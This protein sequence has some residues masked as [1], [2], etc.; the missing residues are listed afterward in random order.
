MR[1]SLPSLTV[2]LALGSMLVGSPLAMAQSAADA[3]GIVVYNA[4]HESLTAGM[5]RRLHQGDRHQGDAAQG[6]RHAS[7]ATRSSQEGAASPGRRVPDRE[8]A[9]HGAG[10]R[11]RPVRAASTPTRW[12]RCPTTSGRR[13]ATGSASPRASTVF[14]YDKTKLTADQLPKSLLDLAD[15][16]WKGRWAASPSGADFQAI[17]S[18]LLRAQ[19]RGG[20]RGLA[21][22]DEGERHRLQRQQRRHEGRQCRRDRRRRDLSLL[23]FR[24]SGEDRREQQQRRRCTISATRIRA[25]SSAISGGGVLAS[26]KHPKRGAGL[27]EMDHRQGRPGHPEDRQFVRIRGRRGRRSPTRSWCRWPTCRRPKVDPSK[28]NSKKVTE[29]MTAAG[30]L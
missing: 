2:A 3:E 25:P 7:S 14:A 8:F 28:L 15:P 12:P 5:G 27:P 11:R 18:A 13:T 4:Q 29:L 20:D 16:S 19:G 26:S 21:E 23:L 30:L 9:G 24:R 1:N 17:V 10:R 22:G 6:Q